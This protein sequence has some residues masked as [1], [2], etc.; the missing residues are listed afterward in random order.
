[1]SKNAEIFFNPIFQK[2]REI[3]IEISNCQSAGKIPR[4]VLKRV[5]LFPYILCTLTFLS[6]MCYSDA[7]KT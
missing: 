7:E 2:V 6:K 4:I 1:M 3:L 5:S